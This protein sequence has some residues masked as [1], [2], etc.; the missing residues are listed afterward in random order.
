M[1]TSAIQALRTT[2]LRLMVLAQA[3]AIAAQLSVLLT[4]DR[5]Q[6]LF[7]Q[8]AAQLLGGDMVVNA[9]REPPA[10]L[11]AAAQTAGLT[12]A[13][14]TLFNS[15]VLSQDKQTLVS[16]KAVDSTYPLR[17]KITLSQTMG[18][19]QLAPGLGQVWV[20][21]NVLK[22]LGLTVGQSLKLGEREFVIAAVIDIEP[23]RGIQFVGFAPRVMLSQ[24]DLPAT[25]LLG[26]GSRATYRWQMAG[27]S[28][29]QANFKTWLAANPTGGLRLETLEEGRPEMRGSLDRAS[30]FLG[31]IAILTTLIAACG[32]GLVAHIWAS[33]QSHSVALMRTLGAST[34]QVAQRLVSQVA[35]ASALGLGLGLLSGLVLHM[36]L[37]QWLVKTEGVSLPAAGLV[38][39]AQAVLLLVVL[40][41]ACVA[42]PVSRLLS[43]QPIAVLRGQ[44]VQSKRRW[45]S[46]ANY[47]G[48][49]LGVSALLV[50]VAGS[51][52][53]GLIVLA[54][55]AGV[56]VLVVGTVFVL[57]RLALKIGRQH[58]YWTVR[59]AARGLL[60][61]PVLTTV[62]AGTLTLA[63]LGIL[64]LAVLQRDVLGAWQSVLPKDAPNHFVFNIQPDQAA[65]VRTAML[66]MG[67]KNPVVQPMIR[68]RLV[69]INQTPVN[70]DN[71]PTE[72]AKNLINREFNMSYNTVMPQGNELVD[73]VWHGQAAGQISMEAGILKTLD[74]K[75][76]DVLGFDVAGQM[77]SYTLSS[78]RKLRWESLNVNFFAISSPASSQALPQTYIAAVFVPPNVDLTQLARPYPNL[79]VLDVGVVAAQGRAVLDKVSRALQLLFGM[80][81]L[82]G[83]LVIAIIAYASR[84]S[85]LRE[86]ALLRVLGAHSRQ[87]QAAQVLEQAGVGL[88]AGLIAGAASFAAV[89]AL[90]VQVLELP[91]SIGLWPLWVG[92]ALGMAV[93]V[94]GYFALSVRFAPTPLGT[95]VRALGL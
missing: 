11:R 10:A 30:R 3:L 43:T 41:F 86:T 12:L 6:Q 50:W 73:G 82:A 44:T 29:A 33:E 88:L 92:A 89:N 46:A 38:P 91:V 55:L 27:S 4:A 20:D 67:I 1:L 75:L 48:A 81:V 77:V 83:G 71:Y 49:A 62:Q 9:D 8:E 80:G 85:R 95:Q 35:W 78:V 32:L 84:L 79:T 17:G 58:R 28:A 40:L 13:R 63:L 22:A 34:R 69:Q 94:L 70:L 24:A 2:P 68:A 37:A 19:Q 66:E 45:A 53:Q 51:A 36:I 59:T 87:V 39:Y 31:L 25:Q 26:L 21:A 5:Y 7:S 61:N 47:L 14:T 52:V 76:G 60:R 65:A 54:A 16:A 15:V 18:S 57:T 42:G 90:A 74:L 72:R 64:M 56:V 23:D 93:N